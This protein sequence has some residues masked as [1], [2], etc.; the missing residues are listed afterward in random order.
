MSTR[1][2]FAVAWLA[3]LVLAVGLTLLAHRNETLPLYPSAD[4]PSTKQPLSDLP[5]QPPAPSATKP[6][7]D[8]PSQLTGP[9]QP[10]LAGSPSAERTLPEVP[11]KDWPIFSYQNLP[12]CPSASAADQLSSEPPQESAPVHPT[13]Y[14]DRALVN[15]QGNPIKNYQLLVVLHET[16]GSADSAIHTFQV[17]HYLDSEQVSYHQIIR[18]D[19]TVVN[20]VPLEKRAYGAGNSAFEGLKGLE[21]V[22]TNP[23][24]PPS[25]NNF[26][27]HI[28]LESP[29]NNAWEA[30]G[31]S[32][33]TN[34]QY[35]SLTWLI[36][37]HCI[38]DSRITTHKAVDR[39]GLRSDP[40]SFEM[41]KLLDLLHQFPAR[42]VANF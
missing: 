4:V 23:S 27:Y 10:P 3:L 17:A 25:V 29:P 12:K 19:G 13:N 22:K 30:S 14:G 21:T 2:R 6:S 41:Q 39:S 11:S 33:Y 16:V 28:S 26:A 7:P 37:R 38:P 31:H 15:A 5:P 35:Q 40:R 8:Q 24:L 9:S 1:L 34:E 18:R 36:A 20:L 32:G 42:E